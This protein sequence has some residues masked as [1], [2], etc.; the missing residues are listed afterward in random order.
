[1]PN[2]SDRP[3]SRFLAGHWSDDQLLQRHGVEGYVG[4]ALT[5]DRC[6]LL[7]RLE[8]VA[9]QGGQLAQHLEP[10]P[11]HVLLFAPD[12]IEPAFSRAFGLLPDAIQVDLYLDGRTTFPALRW[13]WRSRPREPF[14][15]REDDLLHYLRRYFAG[16]GQRRPILTLFEVLDRLAAIPKW[17]VRQRNQLQPVTP[18]RGLVTLPGRLFDLGAQGFATGLGVSLLFL[19]RGLLILASAPR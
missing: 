8:P 11:F 15:R 19:D 14:G 16:R 5:Q 17:R 10:F 2:S 3:I 9:V 7:R 4:Q 1:M 18:H 12:P 6:R 13:R